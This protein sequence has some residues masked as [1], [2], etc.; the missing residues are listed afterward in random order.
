MTKPIDW[1]APKKV[2]YDEA[3]TTKNWKD[4]KAF[5]EKERLKNDIASAA[6]WLKIQRQSKL[7]LDAINEIDD[8]EC[9][10]LEKEMADTNFW[11]F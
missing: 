8:I 11:L 7:L 10:K 2:F 6:I 3:I 9:D 1:H 5:W 4:E